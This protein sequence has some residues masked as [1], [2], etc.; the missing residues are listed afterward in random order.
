MEKADKG[1]QRYRKASV[2]GKKKP[3]RENSLAPQKTGNYSGRL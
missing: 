3:G 2:C 1:E